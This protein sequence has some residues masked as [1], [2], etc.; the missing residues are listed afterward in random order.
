M[1]C[2]L[3]NWTFKD[4]VRF[5]KCHGF[6]F[7]YTNGSHHFYFR[8]DMSNRSPVCVAFHGSKAIAPRVLKSIIRQS[9]ISKDEWS[10]RQ[11]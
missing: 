1:A 10:E 6:V 4:V 5:L 3:H 9:G 11:K 7:S 2:G 8:P